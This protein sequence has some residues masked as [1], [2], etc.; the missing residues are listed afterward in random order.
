MLL[1]YESVKDFFQSD[2]K[3]IIGSQ[4]ALVE[5]MKNLLRTLPFTGV[6]SDDISSNVPFYTHLPS[7]D[8]TFQDTAKNVLFMITFPNISLYTKEDLVTFCFEFPLA[9]DITD[10]RRPLHKRFL[11]LE[12]LDNGSRQ[13]NVCSWTMKF[14]YYGELFDTIH[15]KASKSTHSLNSPWWIYTCALREP[16]TNEED[17]ATWLSEDISKEGLWLVFRAKR[18]ELEEVSSIAFSSIHID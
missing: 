10:V 17:R 6:Y 14:A 5:Q 11:T 15:Q 8:P 18:S 16:N 3:P 12:F 9:C 1:E 2:Y 4:Q 13:E 7:P